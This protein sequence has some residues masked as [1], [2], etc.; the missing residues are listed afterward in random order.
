MAIVKFDRGLYKTGKKTA[1][2][3]Y[4]QIEPNQVWFNRAGMVEAQCFLDPEQFSDVQVGPLTKFTAET[5][6]GAGDAVKIVAQNGAFLMVDKANKNLIIP[7]TA[8]SELGLPMGINYSSEQMYD[9]RT[10]GRRNFFLT[11]KDWL[12][13]IGYT[14]VGM[15]INTNTVQWDNT[16]TVTD[17]ATGETLDLTQFSTTADSY[18]MYQALK[19]YF[20]AGAK[21]P[22]YACVVNGSDGELVIGADPDDA[23]GNVYAQLVKIWDNADRTCS[24]MFQI[25]NKPTA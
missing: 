8:N 9:E 4:G 18:D 1:R 3:G 20:D 7:D 6:P 22:V 23:L 10:R 11:T 16:F 5:A 24:F 15:R 14:A 25:I 17:T 12:P 21:A 2:P 13:R 19:T